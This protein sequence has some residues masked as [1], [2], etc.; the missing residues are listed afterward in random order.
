MTIRNSHCSHWLLMLCSAIID[1]FKYD[2]AIRSRAFKRMSRQFEVTGFS[3]RKRWVHS[4][5][6]SANGFKRAS[7]RNTAIVCTQEH[8]LE[9]QQ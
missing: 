2:G 6:F 4:P 7:F 3:D 8:L 5:I 9:L 1:K